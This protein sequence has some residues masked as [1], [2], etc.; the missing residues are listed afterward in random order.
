MDEKLVLPKKG[1]PGDDG[2]R[3]FSVRIKVETIERLE[4]ILKQTDMSR[5]RLIE[6][7]L[8]FALDR[9]EVEE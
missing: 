5:N 9:C 4:E 6:K 8:D 2:Y 3:V 7:L 1:L